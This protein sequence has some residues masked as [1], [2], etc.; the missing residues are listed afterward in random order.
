[1]LTSST[2]KQRQQP[3]KTK[4]NQNGNFIKNLGGDDGSQFL[5]FNST[6]GDKG[7]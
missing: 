4:N 1:M 5:F 6:T 3:L 7:Q 2:P